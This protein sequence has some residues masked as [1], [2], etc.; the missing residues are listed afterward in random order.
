MNKF[1]DNYDNVMFSGE[2]DDVSEPL[3]EFTVDDE[4]R[5][6]ETSTSRTL[7]GVKSKRTGRWGWINGSGTYVIPAEYDFGWILCYNGIIILEKNGKYGGLYRSGLKTA[8]NFVYD[9]V[10][11]CYRDVYCVHK[12]NRVALMKP[13]EE[14]VTGFDYVGITND[15][16][17]PVFG[18]AKEGYSGLKYGKIN[19]LTGIE[20]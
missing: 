12:N 20:L 19:V 14:R 5:L 15:H 2:Y 7:L 8:F 1:G 10:G 9:Y 16:I 17:G 18:Y 4:G 6:C 3:K 11:Y 13:G